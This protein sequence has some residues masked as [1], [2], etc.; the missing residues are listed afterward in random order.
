MSE[1]EANPAVPFSYRKVRW[2]KGG[3]GERKRSQSGRPDYYPKSWT[4]F[5]PNLATW[6]HHLAMGVTP[7]GAASSGEVESP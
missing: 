7:E 2:R 3:S 6:F 1:S 4:L 5:S